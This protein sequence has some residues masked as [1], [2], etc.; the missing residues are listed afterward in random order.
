MMELVD[1]QDLKFCLSRGPGSSPGAGKINFIYLY[2]FYFNT[3]FYNITYNKIL[4][5]FIYTGITLNLNF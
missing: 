4:N 3:F 2:I 1:M 5:F